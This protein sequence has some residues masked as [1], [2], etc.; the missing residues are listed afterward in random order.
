MTGVEGEQE[1]FYLCPICRSQVTR[2][3][4]VNEV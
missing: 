3:Q 4:Y 2:K 1:G